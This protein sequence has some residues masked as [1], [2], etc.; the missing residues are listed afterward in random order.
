[1]RDILLCNEFFGHKFAKKYIPILFNVLL[2]S[3]SMRT[4][5]GRLC[6]AI[7]MLSLCYFCLAQ[8]TVRV[9]GGLMS[10]LP[11]FSTDSKFHWEFNHFSKNTELELV[12]WEFQ[13]GL[14]C[15]KN[16][17]ICYELLSIKENPRFD[18][19]LQNDEKGNMGIWSCFYGK[20]LSVFPIKSE[21]EPF[22]YLI[23][24]M[25]KVKDKVVPIVFFTDA[26][27]NIDEKTK[28]KITNLQVI[29]IEKDKSL[30]EDLI[31]KLSSFMIL[32]YKLVDYEN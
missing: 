31:K 7:I 1:M 17:V 29:D 23:K 15:V 3:L 25:P 28:N 18:V 22:P 32:S 2:R 14:D 19:V 6:T 21:R 20:Y 5:M 12:L 10:D 9:S 27:I 4:Y 30:F 16:T 8:E 26:N 13:E 11:K 24:S